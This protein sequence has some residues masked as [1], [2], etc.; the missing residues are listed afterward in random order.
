[1]AGVLDLAGWWDA[2]RSDAKRC[3]SRCRNVGRVEALVCGGMESPIRAGLGEASGVVAGHWAQ[4]PPSCQATL[5]Y[6]QPILPSPLGS[7]QGCKGV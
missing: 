3:G 2:M 7:R 6:H 1:M 5:G 4:Q